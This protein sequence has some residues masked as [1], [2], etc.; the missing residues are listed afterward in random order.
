[1]VAFLS[2]YPFGSVDSRKQL[3]MAQE[4]GIAARDRPSE[5]DKLLNDSKS[6]LVLIPTSSTLVFPSLPTSTSRLR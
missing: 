6:S 1:M 2:F 3:Q 4:C 5:L